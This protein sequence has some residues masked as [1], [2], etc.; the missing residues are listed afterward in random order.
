MIARRSRTPYLA[1]FRL[2]A[3]AV[4][5]NLTGPWP[6]QTGHASMVINSGPRPRARQWSRDIYAACSS[7]HG[8]YCASS[9]YANPPCVALYER[10]EVAGTIPPAPTVNR[11]LTEPGLQIVLI[12]VAATLGYELA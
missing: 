7:V 9:M 10:A 4:L 2:D 5:L 6:T 11:A 3:D 8:L 12:N 1:G